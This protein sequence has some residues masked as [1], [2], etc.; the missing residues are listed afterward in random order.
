MRNLEKLWIGLAA[1]AV[2]AGC[3]TV[4]TVT[5]ADAVIA[6]K[7]YHEEPI[8][9]GKVRMRLMLQAQV[10]ASVNTVMW[11]PVGAE[12]GSD[13]EQ[14]D[15]TLGFVASGEPT[16]VIVRSGTLRSMKDGQEAEFVARFLAQ[17]TSI[18]CLAQAGAEL[19]VDYWFNGMARPGAWQCVTLRFRLPGHAPAD[20]LELTLEPISVGGRP[21]RVLPIGFSFRTAEVSA[22]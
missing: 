1:A 13:P 15:I 20:P 12:A 14:V 6:G 19:D 2:L 9:L 18:E 17:G 16:S 4:Q 11:I 7:T 3:S 8:P 22:D 10:V 5:E 21:V